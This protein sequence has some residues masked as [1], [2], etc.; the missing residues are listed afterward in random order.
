M[1]FVNADVMWILSCLLLGSA[2][3]KWILTFCWF[4]SKW[5]ILHW[6]Y[7]RA[8][9]APRAAD[10]R[11]LS[12]LAVHEPGEDRHRGRQSHG[13]V[14]QTDVQRGGVTG[15]CRG[16][17]HIRGGGVDGGGTKVMD[18]LNRLMSSVEVSQGHVEVLEI[19]QTPRDRK[20]GGGASVASV[21]GWGFT[22]RSCNLIS[23][24]IGRTLLDSDV[25]IPSDRTL[26]NFHNQLSIIDYNRIGIN[27]A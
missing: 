17:V 7:Q 1:Y 9:G 25:R 2:S 14:T 10:Q 4:C 3:A 8:P 13:R 11:G 12:P 21:R 16:K 18:V 19:T 5:G 26:V 15:T 22:P 20:W 6:L 27:F 24:V 23:N